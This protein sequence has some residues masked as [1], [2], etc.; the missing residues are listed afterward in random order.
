[1]SRFTPS[2]ARQALTCLAI[3]A[4]TVLSSAPASAATEPEY[5]PIQQNW[6][7]AF[8][9]SIAHPDALPQGINDFGCK[10]TATHPNPIVLVNGTL[11]NMYANWSMYAPVLKQDGYCVFGLNYGGA[12]G[13]PFQQLGELHASGMEI[14]EFVDTVLAATGAEK[15]DMVGH[16]QG[17]LHPI[18]YIN[19]LGGEHKVA[20]VVGVEP[21]T[22]GVRVHG[23]LDWAM[24]NPVTRILAGVAVAAAVDFHADAQFVRDVGTHG[25]TRP[26][27]QYTTIH[28][29]T[30]LLIPIA[31]AQLPPGPNV[32]NIVIQDVCPQDAADHV[33]TV[34]DDV[35]LRLVRN[36]LDPDT[37]A[38][39]M[40]HPVTPLV[41]QTPV[42]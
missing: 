26:G 6:V 30:D 3:A 22:N 28:S 1:M 14:A 10:P 17:G 39:P 7:A 23:V 9:Y 15:V 38:A 27:V 2:T 25:M 8:T 16:S 41:N 21:A 19:N 24:G 29:A 33:T 34:Y 37:A 13:S 36:A 32:T 4:A 42:R 12:T 31:E 11:E 40:C 35:T 18:N 5:G 20:K